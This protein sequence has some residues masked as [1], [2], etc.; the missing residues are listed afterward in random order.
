M[1]L[2]ELLV[3]ITSL[4]LPALFG[5]STHVA[6]EFEWAKLRLEAPDMNNT[7]G[8]SRRHLLPA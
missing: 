7:I 6:Y 2:E 8:A 3:K 1:I 4:T 5:A